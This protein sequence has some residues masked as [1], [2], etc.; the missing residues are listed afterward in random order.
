MCLNFA[1]KKKYI[2]KSRRRQIEAQLNVCK[3]GRWDKTLERAN[4]YNAK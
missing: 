3:K 1:K 4:K 2:L